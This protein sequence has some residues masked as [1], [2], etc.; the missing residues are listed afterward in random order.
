MSDVTAADEEKTGL[1][2]VNFPTLRRNAYRTT[3]KHGPTM[4]SCFASIEGFDQETARALFRLIPAGSKNQPANEHE[5]LGIAKLARMADRGVPEGCEEFLMAQTPSIPVPE[6]KVTNYTIP[7]GFWFVRDSDPN[8]FIVFMSNNMDPGHEVKWYNMTG[9]EQYEW[10]RKYCEGGKTD[11][12]I[13][14]TVGL[15]GTDLSR[16]TDQ[17][18]LDAAAKYSPSLSRRRPPNHAIAAA[19]WPVEPR[20]LD[21]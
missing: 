20:A 15:R 13:A 11:V 3:G 5:A 16:L 4:M 19:N 6:S 18:A 17:A 10:F 21:F 12:R 9:L 8:T 14:N 7:G 1:R 2:Q